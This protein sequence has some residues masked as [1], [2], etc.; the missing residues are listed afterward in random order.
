[1]SSAIADKNES[2]EEFKKRVT[3]WK[4]WNFFEIKGFLFRSSK[5]HEWIVG[6]IEVTL[7]SRETDVK[8]NLPA[9]DFHCIVHEVLKIDQFQKFLVQLGSNKRITIGNI[10]AS[11]ELMLGNFLCETKMRS[12]SEEKYGVDEACLLL[13]SG[14]NYTSGLKDAI[15]KI[16]SELLSSTQFTST[17]SAIKQTLGIDF[18]TYAYYPHV[19]ILAPIPVKIAIEDFFLKNIDYKAIEGKAHEDQSE[20]TK[21]LVTKKKSIKLLYHSALKA[22]TANEKGQLFVSIHD[23]TG[24]ELDGAKGQIQRCLQGGYKIIVLNGEDIE[25]I[26]NC[27]DITTKIDEKYVDLY[28]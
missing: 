19:Q 8:K 3:D 25:E 23:I 11:L 22:T 5:E 15:R 27:K 1:M 28:T 16:D 24:S 6:F 20:V 12:Y 9:S 2:I 14:G 17:K 10:D 4:L 21:D 13:V 7:F 26:L 18:G